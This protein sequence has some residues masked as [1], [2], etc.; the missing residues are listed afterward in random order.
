MLVKDV[1]GKWM[2]VKNLYVGFSFTNMQLL[3]VERRDVGEKYVDEI[4]CCWIRMIL[5]VGIFINIQKTCHQHAFHQ[6][7]ENSNITKAHFVSKTG[8]GYY[9]DILDNWWEEQ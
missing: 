8:K 5:Y 9:R 3:H 6:H 7:S 1:A 2:L 4:V